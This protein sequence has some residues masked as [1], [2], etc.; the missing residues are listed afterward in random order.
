MEEN[1]I[2][3]VNVFSYVARLCEMIWR[4]RRCSARVNAR[5]TRKEGEIVMMSDNEN[6]NE[7]MDS[8]RDE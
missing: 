8:N 7:S 4:M 1:Y 2:N 6:F 5:T 3:D